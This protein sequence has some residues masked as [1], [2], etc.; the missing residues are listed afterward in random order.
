MT[1]DI[2]PT[3]GEAST[4]PDVVKY[5]QKPTSTVPGFISSSEP[6]TGRNCQKRLAFHVHDK[7]ETRGAVNM[8]IFDIERTTFLAVANFHLVNKGFNIESFVYKMNASTEK[9]EI[10]QT[11]PT[12][13]C[14]SM[15]YFSDRGDSYLFAANH[16]DGTTHALDSVIYKWNGTE[17]VNYTTVETQGASAATFFKINSESFFAVANYRNNTSVSIFSIIYKWNRG[18]FEIFQKIPTHG[19]VDCKFYH[20]KEGQMFLVFANYYSVSEGF[21]VKSVVYKWDGQR[22][23]RAQNVEASAAMGVDLFESDDELFLTLASHRTA[24]SWH[25]HTN[26]FRWNGTA[27]A[28]FQELETTAAIKVSPKSQSFIFLLSTIFRGVLIFNQ[29]RVNQ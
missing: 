16:F 7:I 4:Q 1:Y 23:I 9:F 14:R 18:R 22:F 13:G 3:P 24:N 12:V 29:R 6:K 2:I 17:F 10:L 11:L 25:S 19:A 5:T 8:E 15:A 21:N 27:F 26:V 20:R 28:L